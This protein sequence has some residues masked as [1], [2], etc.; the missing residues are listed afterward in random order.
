MNIATA[1]SVCSAKIY[2]ALQALPELLKD[3]PP[4]NVAVKTE[5]PSRLCVVYKCNRY[6]VPTTCRCGSH[7]V[8]QAGIWPFA[9]GSD[10]PVCPW[11]D[12]QA[13]ENTSDSDLRRA[14][15]QAEFMFHVDPEITMRAVAD[16][17]SKRIG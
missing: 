11:C 10:R 12:S 9:M 17:R 4:R 5:A 7:F 16:L 2:R 8:P 3:S 13:M 1:M 6:T 14:A 15:A